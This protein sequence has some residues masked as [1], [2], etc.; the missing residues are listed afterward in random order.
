MSIRCTTRSCAR[1]WSVMSAPTMPRRG[2]PGSGRSR[3]I[4]ALQCRDAARIDFRSDG[5]GEP[6]FLEAN[7]IAGLH[8]C[9]SDLPI[10]AAQNGI[11]FVDLI[12]LILEAGLA[13]YGGK[14]LTGSARSAPPDGTRDER[15]YPRPARGD[16]EPPRRDRHAS[17][18]R[19]RGRRAQRA[20][21]RHRDPRAVA[22]SW[23]AR[24]VAARRPLA[25]FNLV[26]AVDGDG[27][28]AP[29]GAG[30]AR[31]RRLA[32]Y[33][34]PDCRLARHALQSRN[35]AKARPCGPADAGLVRTGPRPPSR[36]TGHREAGLGT[37]LAR[38]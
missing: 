3:P 4:G 9:H 29:A 2:S 6:Y 34:R 35:Q 20:R 23:P 12:G 1:T 13:R 14:D 25:V 5:N 19:G 7:P 15:V 10:L 37:W 27:R 22:R 16:R 36:G 18:G 28:L 21:L 33:G 32:L 30:P 11:D 24:R 38:P 31:C 26:D 17:G 8:P